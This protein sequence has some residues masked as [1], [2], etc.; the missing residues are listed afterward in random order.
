MHRETDV[1][2]RAGWRVPLDEEKNLFMK[3]KKNQMKGR[4]EKA[5]DERAMMALDKRVR[6]GERHRDEATTMYQ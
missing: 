4:K 3:R 5:V 1:K 6:E 2:C